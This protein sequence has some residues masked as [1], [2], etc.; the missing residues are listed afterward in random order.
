MKT[1]Q[2][3]Y[4]ADVY[5]RVE[6]VAEADRKKY[7]SM[8]LQMPS[9]VRTAGLAQALAFLDSRKEEAHKQL[10]TDLAATLE[11][12]TGAALCTDART[13][14]LMPYMHLTQRVM[15]ALDWYKRFAQSVLGAETG[16]DSDDDTPDAAQNTP[17]ET[18]NAS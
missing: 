1:R 12:P 5:A 3:E 18:E 11:K 15:D 17:A 4:A 9:L 6:Q 14:D 16:G 7:G 10:L 2:Q 8:A 13:A